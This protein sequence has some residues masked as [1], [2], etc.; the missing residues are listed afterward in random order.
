MLKKAALALIVLLL[1]GG[2]VFWLITAPSRL[3]RAALANFPPG[4]VAR[5]ERVFWAGGC[6]SCH[7]PAKA[8]GDAELLLA[9]GDALVTPFGS[10]YAPNISPHAD[11]IGNWTLEEFANAM[12]RGVS[13]EGES[14]YPAFPYTSY[15]RMSEQDIADLF[16]FMQRLP[17]VAGEAAPNELSFPFNIRR[18]LGL[19]VRLFLNKDPIVALDEASSDQVR[20][21]QYL[22]EGPAH[23]GQCH[24]AR[25][26]WGMGGLVTAQWLSGAPNAAGQGGIP[27]ITPSEDG[28][29][30]WAQ[31]DIAY[32]LESGFTPEFDTAG[33][34]M[35]EVI[36][37]MARL[38]AEDRNAIAAYLKAI[39]AHPAP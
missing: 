39:P 33:G 31:S 15:A 27:N 28:I 18:G 6:R 13:P 16:A 21:G 26:F 23:C 24:T 2:A 14:Y 35:V 5:G 20:R 34:S 12:Q 37:N 36:K 19:W 4:D 17:A 29:G 11:G 1:M 32:F 3:D 22:V 10:F 8:T 7:A 38:P 9:G 30:S 25:S